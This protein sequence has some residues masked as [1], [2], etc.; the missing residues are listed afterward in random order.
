VRI[1]DWERLNRYP[2][3]ALGIPVF[4]ALVLEHGISLQQPVY[5]P[6][7]DHQGV[8][9]SPLLETVFGPE[10]KWVDPVA[11][12]QLDGFTFRGDI[13]VAIF[14][15]QEL[16]RSYR[17]LPLRGFADLACHP[18]IRPYLT[19]RSPDVRRTSIAGSPHETDDQAR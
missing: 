15:L 17:E 6:G 7:N 4:S 12:G 5:V 8:W 14:A 16:N 1:G 18:R 9:A 10:P 2:A 3:T 11:S 13:E 19:A